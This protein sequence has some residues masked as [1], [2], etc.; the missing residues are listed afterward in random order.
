M[1]LANDSPRFTFAN[2]DLG[3]ISAKEVADDVDA[4]SPFPWDHFEVRL[5]RN[6]SK[7]VIYRITRRNETKEEPADV[8]GDNIPA[9]SSMVE[10][11][12]SVGGRR[13]IPNPEPEPWN[14]VYYDN[15]RGRYVIGAVRYFPLRLAYASTVHKTQGLSLDSVQ[16]DINEGFLKEPAMT[17]V[18]LSRVRTPEGLRIVGR[19]NV[20]VSRVKAAKEVSRWL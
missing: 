11:M 1:I 18:A 15:H 16:L 17:Y 4:F 7:V 3:A 6:G 14:Q 5:K 12:D 19:E 2:G 10:D 20:F 8:Y 9:W 13:L